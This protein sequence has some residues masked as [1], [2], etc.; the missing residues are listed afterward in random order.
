MRLYNVFDGK[1]Q[2]VAEDF[3]NTHGWA[4]VGSTGLFEYLDS[5]CQD[6]VQGF[7]QLHPVHLPAF[8]ELGDAQPSPLFPSVNHMTTLSTSAVDHTTALELGEEDV[9]MGMG[10]VTSP[11]VTLTA[12]A[13]TQPM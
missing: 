7:A 11:L 5:R 10:M 13:D 1:K 3:C 2:P 8:P 9:E 6:V 4:V 12:P